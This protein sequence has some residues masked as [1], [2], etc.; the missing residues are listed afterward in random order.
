M[1]EVT[2]V[3]VVASLSQIAQD[4]TRHSQLAWDTAHWALQT[5][6]SEVR[7][8][9]EPVLRQPQRRAPG[10]DLKEQG[11]A[12]GEAHGRLTPATQQQV[13]ARA[14]Q[15]VVAPCAASLLQGQAVDIASAMAALA[16]HA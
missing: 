8:A 13:I 4:E 10:V 15:Y 12:K 11:C 3:Q 5:G 9:L 16:E 14:V 2:H 6:G 1:T 7:Q